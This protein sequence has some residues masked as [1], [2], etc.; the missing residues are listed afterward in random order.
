M[1]K[2]L[3]PFLRKSL[4]K[5]DKEAH[6]KYHNIDDKSIQKRVQPSKRGS[7]NRFKMLY[8]M[9]EQ[10][11]GMHPDTKKEEQEEVDRYLLL[12]HFHLT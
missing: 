10:G 9:M 11:F 1:A 2:D 6:N 5:L 3:S 7:P 8:R 4:H 12:D